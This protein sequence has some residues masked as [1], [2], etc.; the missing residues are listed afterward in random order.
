MGSLLLLTHPSP[1]SDPDG[2]AA[3][4]RRQGNRHQKVPGAREVAE[5]AGRAAADH[6]QQAELKRRL[7]HAR[8][9]GWQKWLGGGHAG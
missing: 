9:Q 7:R 5:A 1:P 4:A 3:A 6:L 8:N 2:L